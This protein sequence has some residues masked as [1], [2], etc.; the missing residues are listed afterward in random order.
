MATQMKE[1]V[2]LIKKDLASVIGAKPGLAE[3]SFPCNGDDIYS[4]YVIRADGAM[5]AYGE[6]QYGFKHLDA[7]VTAMDRCMAGDGSY[8][9]AAEAAST[10]APQFLNSISELSTD[11]ESLGMVMDGWVKGMPKVQKQAIK[12]AWANGKMSLEQVFELLHSAPLVRPVN[13]Q[14]YGRD[15]I[16]LKEDV[17]IGVL[18]VQA[19]GA[20]AWDSVPL[21]RA[22]EVLEGS[23]R[24]SGKAAL[25]SVDGQAVRIAGVAFEGTPYVQP[26]EE[27]VAAHQA[28]ANGL[29]KSGVVGFVPTVEQVI[30][31]R[32]EHAR[33]EEQAQTV[34]RKLKFS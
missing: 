17:S 5:L 15:T 27:V 2:D 14:V 25:V 8:D 20:L 6:Y 24:S 21:F 16:V 13:A 3:C 4:S 32:E 33:I 18:A 11:P 34:G 12:D 9:A 10:E 31:Q 1:L 30:A 22:G 23:L 28:W 26:P 7:M 19:D 29:A